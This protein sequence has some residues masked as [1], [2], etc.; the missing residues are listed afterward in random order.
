MVFI[1]SGIQSQFHGKTLGYS[2]V[3]G[4]SGLVGGA[5]QNNIIGMLK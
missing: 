4:V 1:I 5:R 2:T 3:T